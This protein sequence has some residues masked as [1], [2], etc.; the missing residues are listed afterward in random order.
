MSNANP[1]IIA[2]EKNNIIF[3]EMGGNINS[4]TLPESRELV[5]EIIKKHEIYK[6]NNLKILVD[7]SNVIDV[8]SATIANILDR[9]AEHKQHHHTIAF[10]N[11]PDEFLHLIQLH[12]LEDKVTVYPSLKEA[13]KVL[14]KPTQ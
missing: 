9:L 14:R 3:I 7:Y 5:N 11:V 12:K 1:Y 8:D 4:E 6:R 10:V 2:K 13:V